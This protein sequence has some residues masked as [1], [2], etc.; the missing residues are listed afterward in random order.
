MKKRMI[1]LHVPNM[2]WNPQGAMVMADKQFLLSVL[3]LP[4]YL[5]RAGGGQASDS[6]QLPDTNK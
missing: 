3:N 4:A 5:S 6:H 1:S 2:L